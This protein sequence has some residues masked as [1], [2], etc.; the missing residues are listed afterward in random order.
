MA[1]DIDIVIEKVR[2]KHPTVVVE[3]LKVTHSGV[4]DDGVWFFR[5]PSEKKEVQVETSTGAAPFIVE[6]DAVAIHGASVD[7]A[8]AEVIACLSK[9]EANQASQPTSLTRRG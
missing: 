7:Q 1:R 2:S 3:Q 5:L 6:G 9:K 8:A 4:D